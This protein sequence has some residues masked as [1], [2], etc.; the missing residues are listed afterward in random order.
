MSKF[1]QISISLILV[2]SLQKLVAQSNP[3]YFNSKFKKVEDVKKAKYTIYTDTSRFQSVFYTKKPSRIYAKGKIYP[4][5]SLTFDGKAVFERPLG[6]LTNVRYFKNG[7]MLP[8]IFVDK[9]LRKKP[10]NKASCYMT[11]SE[12]GYFYAYKIAFRSPDV[13]TDILFASGRVRDTITLNFDERLIEYDNQGYVIEVQ[14]FKNGALIPFIES[15]LDIQ[16]PH[17]T[18]IVVTHSAKIHSVNDVESE[19]RKF[20]KK[21]RD[22][23]ADGVI[24]IKTTLSP[25]GGSESSEM[26][27]VIIQGTTIRLIRD[28]KDGSD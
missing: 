5:D 2:F 26:Q 3:I 18:M 14:K 19:H 13:E 24:G 17:E 27:N 4:A 20:I 16:A 22:T 1:L 11:V 21:C 25:V 8:L 12:K 6:R 10:E 28:K 9:N 23:G 15:T 7:Q